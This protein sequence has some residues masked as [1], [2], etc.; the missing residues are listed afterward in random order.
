MDK[1]KEHGVRSFLRYPRRNSKSQKKTVSPVQMISEH[2]Y[3]SSE[4]ESRSVFV[5]THLLVTFYVNIFCLV[6]S[7]SN[8]AACNAS[9]QPQI[10]DLGLE[11]TE[12]SEK[13]DLKDDSKEKRLQKDETIDIEAA[14]NIE[15]K[16]NNQDF[17]NE[18]NNQNCFKNKIDNNKENNIQYNK[19]HDNENLNE[20]NKENYN[21][22][23]NNKIRSNDC[24]MD[25]EKKCEKEINEVKRKATNDKASNTWITTMKKEPKKARLVIKSEP[26]E[27]KRNDSSSN[28]KP[29]AMEVACYFKYL[30]HID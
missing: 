8:M 3:N 26:A 4:R 6:L 15:T 10:K 27:R 21:T 22:K 16:K 17:L 9:S 19:E 20:N 30:F 5:N 23:N 1:A 25:P 28:G 13:E 2:F 14:I 12:V 7:L 11:S 18:N 24:S 29:T